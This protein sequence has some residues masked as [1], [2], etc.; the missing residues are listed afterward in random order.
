MR[1]IIA[2]EFIVIG[3]IV[4]SILFSPGN[5]LTLFPVMSGFAVILAIS[6]YYGVM[7]KR[8]FRLSWKKQNPEGAQSNE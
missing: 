7:A 4:A 6:F 5:E 8:R 1:K 3:L 2:A